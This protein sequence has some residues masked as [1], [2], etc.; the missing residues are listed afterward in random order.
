MAAGVAAFSAINEHALQRTGADLRSLADFGAT[1]GR[2]RTEDDVARALA[3]TLAGPL[4]FGRVAVLVQEPGCWWGLLAGS[5]GE[6][7][8]RG[9]GEIDPLVTRAWA[10][11]TPLALR[12]VDPDQA[13]LLDRLW[14]DATNVVVIPS[15]GG[16]ALA[17][18]AEWPGRGRGL[19]R[20][21]TLATAAEAT[22]RAGLELQN[23]RLAAE[24]ERL[25]SSDQLTGLANRRV[26]DEQL[27][28][29]VERAA[30]D[31]K[32][33]SLVLFDLDHF[34]GVN[35]TRGH[36]V[37]D[38]VLRQAGAAI[39]G[40]I[41]SEDV[42]AR[43]GG[44]ELAV[45]LPG[46]SGPDALVMAQRL[47]AAIAEGVTVCRVTASAGVATF[48]GNATDGHALVARAD[49]ALYEAKRSGRDQAVRARTRVRRDPLAASA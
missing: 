28:V 34:K 30:R 44:E 17:A 49:R 32:S 25:A 12:R 41:R 38:A 3:D 22:T 33:M 40:A 18:V 45:L 48:P 5:T 27:Q 35:D 43:Y 24:V 16:A 46:C 13:P 39:K 2:A 29:L 37:G 9:D 42:A 11:G 31:R 1:L 19:L 23:V 10:S 21:N 7:G 26:F 47:R 6:I 20:A 15:A 36:Q 8:L 14:F 4:G